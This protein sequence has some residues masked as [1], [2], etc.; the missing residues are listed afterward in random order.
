MKNFNN[1]KLDKTMT[2]DKVNEGQT[3][4]VNSTI[5]SMID[6]YSETSMYFLDEMANTDDDFKLIKKCFADKMYKYTERANYE[7]VKIKIYRVKER[8]VIQTSE[9]ESEN[10]LLFHGTSCDSAV[11]ILEKGFRPSTKGKYGAGVYLTE[12][13]RCA[14]NVSLIR[15]GDHKKFL[16]FCDN[17]QLNGDKSELLNDNAHFVFV[18]EIIQSETL[19]EINDNTYGLILNFISFCV[20]I[21][22]LILGYKKEDKFKRYIVEGTDEKNS[23]EYYEND[24]SGRKIKVCKGNGK[25]ELNH[26]VCSEKLVIPRYLI[27]CSSKFVITP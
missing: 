14:I 13:S 15:N 6:T 17:Y 23:E 5:F 22:W 25:D 8:K 26:Y 10:M 18:N 11:G 1:F 27:Q 3:I 19:K 16:S 9:H 2:T 7:V 21:I 4:N 24:S 20:M 12:R